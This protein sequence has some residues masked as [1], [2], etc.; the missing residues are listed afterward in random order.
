MIERIKANRW[1]Y[2]LNLAISIV[3]AFDLTWLLAGPWIV[4][5]FLNGRQW[6]GDEEMGE[7]MHNGTPFTEM[8][9]TWQSLVIPLFIGIF[10]GLAFLAYRFL[11]IP[12][13]IALRFG[14]MALA[15]LIGYGW[16]KLVVPSSI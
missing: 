1:L 4:A 9:L 5:Q 6:F 7:F 13:L 16:F 3:M 12:G 2:A 11:G 14:L 10:A 8:L 15:H